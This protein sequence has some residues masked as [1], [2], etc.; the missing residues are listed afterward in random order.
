M[1]VVAANAPDV[2]DRK[3]ETPCGANGRDVE[4]CGSESASDS[5]A[6]SAADR[7]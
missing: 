1:R 7:L 3:G 6:A 2:V 5:A 4:P